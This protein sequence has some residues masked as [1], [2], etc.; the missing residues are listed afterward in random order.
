MST[1]LH[2]LTCAV[3]CAFFLTHGLAGAVEIPKPI[4]NVYDYGAKGDGEAYDTAALE[5]AIAAC[6]GTGGSVY[7]PKGGKFKT[8]QIQLKGRMTFYIEAGATL[9]G[10]TRPEDYPVLLPPEVE[11]GKTRT[12][13]DCRRSV[14]YAY[15][16]DNLTITGGGTL[17]GQGELLKM[18]GKE[19]KRPL[20]MRFFR[21]KNLTVSH[22]KLR[23][24]RMWT[25]VYD[26]CSH[27]LIEKLDIKA[28]PIYH[29]HD[30]I[31][32]CDS[33]HVVIRDNVVVS[34][35]DGI[36]LKSMCPVGLKDVSITNNKIF[37]HRANG[38]K[39]G[40]DT[41]G[42]ITD[43]RIIDNEVYRASLGGICLESVDGSALSEVTVKNL[44]LADTGQ[45]IYIRLAKRDRGGLGVGSIRNILIE[46]V[47]IIGTHGTGGSTICGVKGHN[48]ENVT[49]K[50]IT[51]EMPGGLDEIPAHP[52]EKDTSYPQ[53][54]QFG[55]TPAY[56]L[57]IRH[58]RNI[59]LS[60]IKAG[61]RKTDARPW[62]E[63]SDA[64]VNVDHCQDQKWIKGTAVPVFR[65]VS[66]AKP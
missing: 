42:P 2:A 45:P 10:G 13:L 47:R 59:K 7:L 15:K 43:I 30:G 63:K 33:S 49:L 9:L 58:A 23:N 60:N 27:L 46:N 3:V 8:A 66:K 31:D 14:L 20:L 65:P 25:Q 4:H 37:N 57:Y 61:Y 21:C 35:D 26:Q 56:G 36:V 24:P 39:I 55:K 51:M 17:D 62:Y 5:K 48:I 19:G 18:T 40:T 34:E 41:Q 52:R 29:N 28:P 11:Y 22:L 1:I 50:N 54:N 64:S 38:I 6:A 12:F 32:V 53:S 16:A 44:L